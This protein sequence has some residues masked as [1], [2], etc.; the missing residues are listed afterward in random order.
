MTQTTAN[1]ATP[2]TRDSAKAERKRIPMSTPVQKLSVPDMP[3]YHLHW[4][5][6]TED[7]IQRA[8][9][10]GYE[11]VDQREMRTNATGLGSDSTVSGN[12]DM[13]SRVS[14]VG[15][16]E[17]GRDGQAVRLILM[18]IKQEWWLEDQKVIE[19]RS[20][21]VVASLGMG[22]IGSDKDKVGDSQMR[23]VDK[24]RTKIPDMFIKKPPR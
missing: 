15:G 18:K 2:A 6:G 7:R 22:A 8:L 24:S 13:G 1:P 23:Y 3:G 21:Q 12:T 10:G 20:D 11:F 9:D 4:F 14:V 5:N 16:S 19:A 17:L